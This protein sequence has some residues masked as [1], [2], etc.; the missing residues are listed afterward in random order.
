MTSLPPRHPGHPRHLR[1]IALARS[2][3]KGSR[4]T[5]SIVALEPRHFALIDR[6]LTTERL[7]QVYAAAPPMGL[8][9]PIHRIDRYALPHLAAVHCVMHGALDGGVTRS[10]ALDAHGKSLSTWVLALPLPAD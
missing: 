3:D 5:L 7:Q 9:L 4:A 1:D 2:G 6:L 10:L 8:G